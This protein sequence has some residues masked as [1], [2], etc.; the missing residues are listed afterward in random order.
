MNRDSIVKRS[1]GTDTLETLQTERYEILSQLQRDTGKNGKARVLNDKSTSRKNIRQAVN[2]DV[3]R[4]AEY[5][6]DLAEHL[7]DAFKWNWMCYQPD[8]DPA[9]EF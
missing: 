3:K 2:C 1:S 4:T 6:P 5:H 9:W 7:L 8:D